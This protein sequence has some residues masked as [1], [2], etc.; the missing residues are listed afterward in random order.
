MQSSFA[1]MG[2]LLLA[3]G[4]MIPGVARAAE[5]TSSAVIA[6][7][8]G[9]P[10]QTRLYSLKRAAFSPEF[11]RRMATDLHGSEPQKALS[12]EWRAPADFV[13]RYFDKDPEVAAG[14]VNAAMRALVEEI[15]RRRAADPRYGSGRVQVPAK[16]ISPESRVAEGVVRVEGLSWTET[17]RKQAEAQLAATWKRISDS[18]NV[19]LALSMAGLLNRGTAADEFRILMNEVRASLTHRLH[20]DSRMSVKMVTSDIRRVAVLGLLVANAE[21]QEVAMSDRIPAADLDFV[22]AGMRRDWYILNCCQVQVKE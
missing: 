22:P 13:V 8:P 1:R 16:R 17:D 7:L 12:A 2:V 18:A 6:I 4:T 5:Y 20:D 21:K 15:D 3:A 9:N 10:Y 14:V 19:R 11:F